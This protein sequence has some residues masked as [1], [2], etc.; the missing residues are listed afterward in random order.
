MHSFSNWVPLTT[1]DETYDCP[2]NGGGSGTKKRILFI[3]YIFML[4][5]SHP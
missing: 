4:I 1:K 3:V 2:V 5:L